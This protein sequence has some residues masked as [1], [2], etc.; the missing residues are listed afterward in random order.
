MPPNKS[1][2]MP[3]SQGAPSR[4]P[5][6]GRAGRTCEAWRTPGSG[7]LCTDSLYFSPW[8]G[9]LPPW[10]RCR[11][12]LGPTG[13]SRVSSSQDPYLNYTCKDPFFPQIR[14]QSQGWGLGCGHSLWGGTIHPTAAGNLAA[15]CLRF[16]GGEWTLIARPD[17]IWPQWQFC[18][19]VLGNA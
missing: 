8:V 2:R 10:V 3:C 15:L 9:L 7:E 1:H 19:C 12:I 16:G 18:G 5:G 14:S 17:P 6:H 4:V 13:E 11:W